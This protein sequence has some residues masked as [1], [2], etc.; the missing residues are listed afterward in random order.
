MIKYI[1]EVL[2]MSIKKTLIYIK[3]HR[4]FS[5]GD[6][7]KVPVPSSQSTIKDIKLLRRV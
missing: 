4:G 5:G 6:R 7:V 1:I 2:C 3:Y